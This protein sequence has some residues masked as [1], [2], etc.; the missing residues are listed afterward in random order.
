M[1]LF[2][3]ACFFHSITLIFRY[4]SMKL[5][6]YLYHFR[7]LSDALAL[8]SLP[9]L[10]NGPNLDPTP[11]PAGAAGFRS[12]RASV[13][14]TAAAAGRRPAG[15]FGRIRRIRR[16][17]LRR[18]CKFITTLSNETKWQKFTKE[19]IFFHTDLNVH[20]HGLNFKAA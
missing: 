13:C 8:T 3:C 15:P 11:H 14:P 6:F 12:C 2:Y 19:T 17:R 5:L 18:S 20:F 9:S 10:P 1:W 4:I 7:F 16:H